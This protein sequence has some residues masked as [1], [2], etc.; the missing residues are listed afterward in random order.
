MT[1]MKILSTAAK[2]EALATRLATIAR[3]CGAYCDRDDAPFQRRAIRL[4]LGAGPRWIT[5]ELDGDSRCGAL[6]GHWCAEGD[7]TFPRDFGATI[8]GSINKI[9]WNKAT[10][11]EE[12]ADR[13][14]ASIAA[15]LRRCREL[16]PRF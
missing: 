14:C 1:R 7:A 8:D 3:E 16:T 4:T 2:R 11:C 9:H 13:F 6:L 10:T 5:I 12:S 15:G